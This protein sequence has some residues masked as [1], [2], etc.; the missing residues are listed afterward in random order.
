MF[1]DVHCHLNDKRFD[2]DLDDVIERAEKSGVAV[3]NS[4]VE[5]CEIKEALEFCNRYDNVYLTIGCSPTEFDEA[6]IEGIIKE[7][8]RNKDKIVGVGEVGLDYYWVK[9]TEKHEKQKKNFRKFI[10][11]SNELNLPLV[12]HSR[13][14]NK[15]VLETLGERSTPAL[16]HCFSGT[17]EE[18]QELINLGC[19]ISI[20]TSVAHSK[21]RQDVAKKVPLE[22]MTLETDAPYMAPVP[23]ARNE[24]ANVVSSAKKIAEIKGVDAK[25][26]EEATTRNAKRFFRIK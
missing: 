19:L 20:P 17:A 10:E 18:A 9:E 3:I 1:F 7:I 8:R 26:V 15:D 16:M 14:S 11:L 5:L 2:K 23:K 12:V 24:P 6:E 4:T 22:Q 21:P 25:E 13:E